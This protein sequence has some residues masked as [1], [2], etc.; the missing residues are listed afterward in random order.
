MDPNLYGNL[1]LL[2]WKEWALC[3]LDKKGPQIL[4]LTKSPNPVSAMVSAL[5]KYYL[6]F[7]DGVINAEK[8][9]DFKAADVASKMTSFPDSSIHF[10]F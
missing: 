5:A 1:C 2:L 7:Y 4:F 8:F 3:F 6:H 9:P 10:F